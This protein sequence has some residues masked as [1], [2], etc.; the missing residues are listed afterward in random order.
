MAEDPKYAQWFVKGAL[1]K[2]KGSSSS[3]S[4]RGKKASDDEE[5]ESAKTKQ[6]KNKRGK[7]AKNAVREQQVESDEEEE[8]DEED[9][10]IPAADPA[11]EWIEVIDN[12]QAEEVV[13]KRLFR[14]TASHEYM[15]V[16][17]G[18]IN[19]TFMKTF[20]QANY[21]SGAVVLG[22]GGV[23]ESQV[24]KNADMIFFCQRGVARVTIH[25]TEIL[26]KKGDT[27]CAPCHNKYSIVNASDVGDA[28]LAFFQAKF[29]RA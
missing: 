4:K 22:P 13:V 20:D 9:A 24:V 3:G 15:T 21:S 8:E 6:N 10:D 11:D 7:K 29:Q 16:P 1:T 2:R 18:A 26:V 28:E 14:P 17:R 19:T 5:D 25:E 27:F 23:K 12:D